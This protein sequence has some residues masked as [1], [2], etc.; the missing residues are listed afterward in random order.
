MVCSKK[1]EDGSKVDVTLPKRSP[2]AGSNGLPPLRYF[3]RVTFPPHCRGF[4]CRS[5]LSWP[6]ALFLTI[7]ASCTVRFL[8]CASQAARGIHLKGKSRHSDPFCAPPPFSR[9]LITK[10]SYCDNFDVPICARRAQSKRFCREVCRSLQRI[11][12]KVCAITQACLQVLQRGDSQGR[13][14]AALL[15]SGRTSQQL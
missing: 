12:S 7:A 10:G 3:A 14:R 4:V 8:V 1:L 13:I 15:C 5:S 9:Y 11:M 2:P 6:N